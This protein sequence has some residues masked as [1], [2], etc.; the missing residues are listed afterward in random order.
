MF[1]GRERGRRGRLGSVLG[2]TDALGC[3]ASHDS[4]LQEEQPAI[5]IRFLNESATTDG[6][7]PRPASHV[8]CEQ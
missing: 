6:A 4:Q 2:L 1:R 5:Q 3:A 7:L 8:S